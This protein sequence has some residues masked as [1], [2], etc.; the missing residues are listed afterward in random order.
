MIYLINGNI[1]FNA[2]NGSLKNTGNGREVFL[3]SLNTRILHLLINSGADCLPRETLLER[4]WQ[5]YGLIPAPAS[6]NQY[7]SVT[8]RTLVSIGLQERLI[9]TVAKTGYR[10]NNSIS[11]EAIEAKTALEAST[12]IDANTLGDNPSVGPEPA[13]SI[14]ERS[15]PETEPEP[16]LKTEV[17]SLPVSGGDTQPMWRVVYGCTI[18]ILL[19]ICS[20][21]GFFINKYHQELNKSQRIVYIGKVNSCP[22]YAIN[23]LRDKDQRVYLKFLATTRLLAQECAADEAILAYTSR[24]L[25]MSEGSGHQFIAKCSV[26]TQ[27]HYYHCENE[28]TT[29]WQLN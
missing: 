1:A 12:A 4:A 20:L 8:R 29:S 28:Y 10:I 14:P 5:Q 19:I 23:P 13:V 18:V 3:S 24:R 17:S 11:I 16:E 6:L 26:D 15:E 25:D 7:I 22:I 27:G 2:E 21:L 9:I